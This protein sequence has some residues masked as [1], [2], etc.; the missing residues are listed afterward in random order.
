[1]RRLCRSCLVSCSCFLMTIC[2]W[3]RSPITTALSASRCAMR[4]EALCRQSCC[5]RRF[6]SATRLYTLERWMYRRGFFFHSDAFIAIFSHF[7]FFH[8]P[9]LLPAESVEPP[10]RFHPTAS[11][12]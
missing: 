10:F 4:W 11:L 3:E 1:M 7:F 2:L 8:T 6:F 5:L 12:F 9:S